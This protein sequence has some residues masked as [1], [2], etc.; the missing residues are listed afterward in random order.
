MLQATFQALCLLH[1]YRP[2]PPSIHKLYI[3]PAQ[4]IYLP[5]NSLIA[6]TFRAAVGSAA[7]AALPFYRESGYARVN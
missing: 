6:Q 4:G 7:L 1:A 2:P 3:L 5:D